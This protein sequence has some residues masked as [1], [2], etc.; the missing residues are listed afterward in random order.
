PPLSPEEAARAA[1]RAGLPLDGERHA[2][3]AAVARTVHEVLSRLRD[4]DYGDTPPALSG[5]P[6]GR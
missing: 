4:L 6:E 5:T 1:H 3:V 2:P